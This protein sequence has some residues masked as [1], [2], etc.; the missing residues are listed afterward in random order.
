MWT[1]YL[2]EAVLVSSRAVAFRGNSGYKLSAGASCIELDGEALYGHVLVSHT[3]V[4][5][6]ADAASYTAAALAVYAAFLSGGALRS[7]CQ[8]CCVGARTVVC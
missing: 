1:L 8:A 2:L 7:W 3:P 5:L 4:V 6:A